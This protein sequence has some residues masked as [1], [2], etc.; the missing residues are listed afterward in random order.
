MFEVN[1]SELNEVVMAFKK[2]PH[3]IFEKE[4]AEKALM[5]ATKIT[6]DSMRALTPTG[7]K[8]FIPKNKAGDTTYMRG[9]ALRK[10]LRRKLSRFKKFGETQVIVGY[11]KKSGLAGWRAHFVEH[12]FTTRDGQFIK[13][14][15]FMRKAE[16]YTQALVEESF[17]REI[18]KAVDNLIGE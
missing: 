14:Q 5:K 7:D 12:G 1:I 6:E 17:V 11:S 13:G 16:T 18:Q 2:L 15:G 4:V 10:S 3:Q 8:V 9:G